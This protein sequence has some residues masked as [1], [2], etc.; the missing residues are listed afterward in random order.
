MNL[1]E[2]L[3]AELDRHD[4]RLLLDHRIGRPGQYDGEQDDRVYLPVAG[5]SCQIVLVY[6]GAEMVALEQ[7]PAF[8]A[9]A[10]SA[11]TH[12]A[13]T[14]LLG[15]PLKFGRDISFSSYRVEGSWRGQKS[16]VQILPAPAEAPSA[17]VEMAQHPFILEFPVQAAN[18][19]AITNSRRI[20]NHRRYTFLLNVLISGRTNLLS[21]QSEHFWASVPRAPRRWSLNLITVR[22]FLPFGSNPSVRFTKA[23]RLSSSSIVGDWVRRASAFR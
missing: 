18:L 9:S 4:L 7:G 22:M 2:K 19:W 1:L 11:L 13:H 8:D 20:R 3:P 17:P 16:G 5:D 10:W 15:G 14:S 23:V 12:E 6:R 21:R